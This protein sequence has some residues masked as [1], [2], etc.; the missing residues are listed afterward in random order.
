[1][2]VINIQNVYCI[3][4]YTYCLGHCRMY[5]T[6]VLSALYSLEQ[7]LL[8]SFNSTNNTVFLRIPVFLECTHLSIFANSLDRLLLE[9][10]SSHEVE[11]VLQLNRF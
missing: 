7:R 5:V 2:P 3:L 9:N 6:A 8:L 1:M 11:Q 4:Q 10:V